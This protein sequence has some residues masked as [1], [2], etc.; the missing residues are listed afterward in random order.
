MLGHFVATDLPQCNWPA[1]PH[2]EAN[3]PSAAL[4]DGAFPRTTSRLGGYRLHGLPAGHVASCIGESASFATGAN[5]QTAAAALLIVRRDLALVLS[6][7]IRQAF[8]F[9]SLLC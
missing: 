4:R 1:G 5:S 6:E 3:A 8:A 9:F 2:P 7:P